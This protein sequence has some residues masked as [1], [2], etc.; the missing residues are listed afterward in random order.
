MLRSKLVIRARM[1]DDSKTRLQLLN[2]E[3]GAFQAYIQGN[4]TIDLSATKQQADRLMQRILKKQ[5]W[6]DK[7]KETVSA[8]SSKRFD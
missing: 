6:K 1:T 5:E 2:R 7:P 8:H 3:Y 4:K